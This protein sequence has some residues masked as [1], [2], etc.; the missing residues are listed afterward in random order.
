M[1][2]SSLQRAALCSRA[3]RPRVRGGLFGIWATCG[4]HKRRG[5]EASVRRVRGRRRAAGELPSA[6]RAAAPQPS[7]ASLPW[8]QAGTRRDTQQQRCSVARSAASTA[9]SRRRPARSHL[10]DQHHRQAD[11]RLLL[12]PVAAAPPAVRAPARAGRL[13]APGP[14]HRGRH[15]LLLLL[16]LLPRP[17]RRSTAAAT[18]LVAA[19][20]RQR[21]GLQLALVLS[22]GAGRELTRSSSGWS[23]SGRAGW[24]ARERRRAGG[25][26]Q[27]GGGCTP[28]PGAAAGG[29]SG[30]LRSCGMRREAAGGRLHTNSAAALSPQQRPRPIKPIERSVCI[31]SH[32]STPTMPSLS[33]S[34]ALKA[35]GLCALPTRGGRAPRRALAVSGAHLGCLMHMH[36]AGWGLGGQQQH[37]APMRVGDAAASPLLCA[38][39][40]PTT[41]PIAP[42]PTNVPR[43]P[44]RPLQP[45]RASRRRRRP[46]RRRRPRPR[47]SLTTSSPPPPR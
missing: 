2:P 16:L 28:W 42:R 18:A 45:P 34:S 12:A 39:P 30:L 14:A 17:R 27:F 32:S 21:R 25:P 40:H 15:L 23:S 1:P 7:T 8:E 11:E 44:P 10:L 3:M 33:S 41:A 35:S 26:R 38:R 6:Q 24:G 9:Q 5:W 36:A 13:V 47:P 22:A 19:G 20:R 29:L 37:C 43:P 31:A 4:T 46:L